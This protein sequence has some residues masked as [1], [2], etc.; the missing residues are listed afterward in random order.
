MNDFENALHQGFTPEDMA[1]EMAELEKE[2][3]QP[4]IIKANKK[5]WILAVRA[6]S[7]SQP[8]YIYEETKKMAD[9]D[10]ETYKLNGFEVLN[11]Y[12][13]PKDASVYYKEGS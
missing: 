4:K 11:V 6:S 8:I 9:L 5:G 7:S 3:S 1:Q 13:S 12:Q 2:L 10:A